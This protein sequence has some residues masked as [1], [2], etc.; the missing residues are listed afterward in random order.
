MSGLNTGNDKSSWS[1]G[2]EN[3]VPMTG[4]NGL[5]ELFN[6]PS[7]TSEGR[8][9]RET[10]ETLKAL[11]ELYKAMQNSTT[12]AQQKRI[13]PKVETLTQGISPVLPGLGFSVVVGG[14]TYVMPV[15]FSNGGLTTSTERITANMQNGIVQNVSVPI[16]PSQYIDKQVVSNVTEHYKRVGEGSGAGE[17]SVINTQV[18]DLDMW[19]H[20]ES[21]D[22]KEWPER[23]AQFL[24]AE[25]E[26]AIMVKATAEIMAQN[27]K[28]PVS[29][30]NPEKPY[31]NDGAAEAR[32]VAIPGQR[33]NRGNILTSSNLE[34]IATTISNNQNNSLGVNN[35]K[36]ICRVT[37]T[38]R[39][40]GVT[41]NEHVAA[42]T[43]Q[44]NAVGNNLERLMSLIVGSGMQPNSCYAQGY[45]PLRPIIEIDTVS[46]GEVLQNHNG[47]Y[48]F[49]YGLY[50]LMVS[51]NRYAFAEGVRRL[52]GAGRGSLVDLETR[53]SQMIQTGNATLINP[54]AKI[55][56]TEKNISD[57]DLVNQWLHQN[58]SPHLSFHMNLLN[59]GPYASVHNFMFRLAGKNNSSEI[60]IVTG[61]IDAM[62]KNKFSELVGEN[63]KNGSGWNPSKPVLIPT[64]ILS[65]NGITT[66]GNRRMN[67]SEIDEQMICHI[68]GSKNIPG[69]DNYLQ[70]VYGGNHNEN[71]KQRAQKL[72]VELSHGMF[73][74]DVAINGFGQTHIWNPE[75]L[76][77]MGKAYE[78][79]GNL[80]IANSFG[81]WKAESASYAPGAGLALTT[82]VGTTLGGG[83]SNFGI[84]FM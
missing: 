79:I 72:R 19:N 81:T 80:S 9:L 3:K 65:V 75:F 12:N 4:F 21:G 28:L 36:E 26:E 54:S 37:A 33:V 55:T 62:T 66:Y 84:N 16:P 48:P 27:G 31:G 14:R 7:M 2:E 83:M 60:Q 49:F 71:L 43:G 18:V 76:Q 52:P 38:V 50:L 22:P 51:N 69:I 23:I 73:D 57:V 24:A 46:A 64:P 17:V 40:Q 68:K 61:L 59:S 6:N 74:T 29:W 70:T 11:T 44:Q 58:C 5:V 8:N 67:T 39:L 13:I 30:Q 25:W 77:V 45:K 1:A 82:S 47:L 53:I 15:L 41:W 42:M 20:P 56:L 32:V 10:G 63:I 78:T 34:I 35:S